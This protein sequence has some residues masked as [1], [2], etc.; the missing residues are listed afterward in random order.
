MNESRPLTNDEKKASEAAFQG[1]P[2][3]PA[4]SKS[5]RT[6]YES[7]LNALGG[8]FL[9]PECQKE[10]VGAVEAS[11]LPSD[12]LNELEPL[13]AANSREQKSTLQDP[14]VPPSPVSGIPSRGDAIQAG[15]VID[16]SEIA[17]ELGMDLAVGITK[18]LWEKNVTASTWVSS[19]EWHSRVRDMLLAV[20]LRMAYLENLAPWFEVPVLLAQDRDERPKL[21]PIYVLFHKD[22]ITAECLTLIHPHEVSS[23]KLSP[24]SSEEDSA[25]EED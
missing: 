21:F 5:A 8:T 6:I 9:L 10:P 7:L 22:P 18:S 1:R 11:P 13:P 17:K 25:S 23:L 16:V 3:D 20:R 2:F 4:W 19:E 24:Q 14:H 15:L 12:V